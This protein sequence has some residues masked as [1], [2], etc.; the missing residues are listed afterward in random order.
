M[1]PLRK[2]SSSSPPYVPSVNRNGCSQRSISDRMTVFKSLRYRM[3]LNVRPLKFCGS[4]AVMKYTAD[5]FFVFRMEYVLEKGATSN[6]LCI[7]HPGRFPNSISLQRISTSSL[8]LRILS[9][10][11]HT[12]KHSLVESRTIVLLPMCLRLTLPCFH[13]QLQN[14]VIRCQLE[15]LTIALVAFTVNNVTD[16]NRFFLKLTI[17]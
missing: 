3:R 14:L 8:V 10:T 12:L 17:E 5:D 1:K 4:Y 15:I 11:T 2:S 16:F 6:P 9:S 13:L 7:T